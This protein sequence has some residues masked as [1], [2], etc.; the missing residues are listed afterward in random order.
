MD[1]QKRLY[2]YEPA[3][4][5]AFDFFRTFCAGRGVQATQIAGPY[6]ISARTFSGRI[7]EY[8]ALKNKKS[9]FYYQGNWDNFVFNLVRVGFF[10]CFERSFSLLGGLSA[11]KLA[12]LNPI[13]ALK[14]TTYSLQNLN[15]RS[16]GTFLFMAQFYFTHCQAAKNAQ[17]ISPS[18]KFVEINPKV[19]LQN[20]FLFSLLSFPLQTLRMKMYMLNKPDISIHQSYKMFNSFKVFPLI[21]AQYIGA[22][23]HFSLG[24]TFLVG[25]MAIAGSKDW[26]VQTLMMPPLAIM[27][28]LFS[29]QSGDIYR[30][31]FHPT[32][33]TKQSGLWKSFAN[34]RLGM[35]IGAAF[36]MFSV[37]CSFRFAGLRDQASLWDEFVHENEATYI[38]KDFHSRTRQ[39]YVSEQ[40]NRNRSR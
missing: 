17:Q 32:V 10:G 9:H 25:G 2:D 37:F 4:I 24:W 1:T 13:D 36:A 20:T 8:Y 12:S 22:H 3:N 31:L 33:D 30:R 19:Y 16:S 23:L 5:T 6:N 7:D 26:G 18:G 15:F 29:L 38:S 14:K 21:N 35:G 28:Y 40:H 27:Y 11:K 34:S 39:F